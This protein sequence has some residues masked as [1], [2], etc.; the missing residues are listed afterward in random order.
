MIEKGVILLANKI[1]NYIL[2]EEAKGNIPVVNEE[3][4]D[5]FTKELIKNDKEGN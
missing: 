1:R 4:I 3:L 2:T 5:R